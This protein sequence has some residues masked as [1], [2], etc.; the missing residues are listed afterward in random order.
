MAAW[1]GVGGREQSY[2]AK[3]TENQWWG[4][5]HHLGRYRAYQTLAAAPRLL[6]RI[7]LRSSALAGKGKRD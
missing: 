4:K 1:A 3:W 7:I 5:R 6:L 2:G